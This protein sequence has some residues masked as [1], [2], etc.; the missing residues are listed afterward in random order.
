MKVGLPSLLRA[1]AG[2]E[3]AAYHENVRGVN[4]GGYEA[5]DRSRV[6]GG[7]RRGESGRLYSRLARTTVDP[8]H[9]R[10]GGVRE[11]ECGSRDRTDD[12]PGGS[13]D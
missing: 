6:S 2:A 3:I 10:P 12:A 8:P 7:G 1:G 5:C 13:D 4:G 9:H 11:T